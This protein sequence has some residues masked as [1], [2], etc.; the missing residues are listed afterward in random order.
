[1]GGGGSY[2][3]RDTTDGYSRN[4]R[5]VSQ[6]AEEEL[7]RRRVDAGML[8]KGRRLVCQAKSP[9]VYAFDVTGSMGT[10]PKTIF[11][12]MPM[13]AGQIAENGYLDDPQVCIAAV[14][15]V[16]CDSAPIQVG[17]FTLIRNLDDWLKRVWLEGGG[18][19]NGGESYE[20][21]GYFF[22]RYCEIPEAVTPF[23]LI[24]GD[25]DFR[26]TLY[27]SDLDRHFGG[28]HE[29]TTAREVFDSLKRKFKN[30]VFL[31]HRYFG[32]GDA[33]IVSH[34]CEL[35][36]DEHVVRLG[37]DTAVADVTLGLFAIMTGSRSLEE[38]LDDMKT[39]RQV[40]Q[41]D[42]RVAE[43][44]KSLKPLLAIAPKSPIIAAPS[45]PTPPTGK[46]KKKPPAAG[47]GKGKKPGRL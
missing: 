22:D 42:A 30:N 3:D 33:K 5:G 2:Y 16:R 8:P 28:K 46:G 10:L 35:L 17:D 19:G 31:I 6:R 34:W 45:A 7:S 43:V 25:E 1:M 39:K 40:A 32:D 23:L 9:V 14:G 21:A 41:T 4:S 36:G 47:K 44:R 20:Y 26:D 29:E 24:T 12:K 38:Y 15:D 11:D 18:G 13:I 27:K 37:S